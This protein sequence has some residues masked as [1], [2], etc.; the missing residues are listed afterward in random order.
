MVWAE[1][2]GGLAGGA[3]S[4]FGQ[5]SAASAQAAQLKKILA[6]LKQAQGQ[7][8]L[9]GALALQARNK[10]LRAIGTGYDQALAETQNA[11]RASELEAKDLAASS[12]SGELQNLVSAGMYSP[13]AIQDAR[14]GVTSSLGR[15]LAQIREGTAMRR[16]GLLTDRGNAISGAQSGIAGQYVQNAQLA[17]SPLYAQADVLGS[18]QPQVPDVSGVIGYGIGKLAGL[19]WSNL[20]GGGSTPSTYKGKSMSPAGPYNKWQQI[21]GY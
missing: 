16:A 11:G 8:Q 12:F 5:K 21:P 9:G 10:G 20:F 6:L 13:Q 15:T 19:D 3:A 4:Y 14:R 1:L 7:A 2:V 18:Y 17:T